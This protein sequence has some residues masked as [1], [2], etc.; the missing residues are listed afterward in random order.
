MQR[1]VKQLLSNSSSTV[2]LS[3]RHSY[4]FNLAPS[5]GQILPLSTILVFDN[6][7]AKLFPSSAAVLFCLVPGDEQAKLRCE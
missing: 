5:S 4:A 1:E 6:H 2:L 7:P 3:E